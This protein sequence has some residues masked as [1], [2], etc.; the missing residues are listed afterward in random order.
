MANTACLSTKQFSRIFTEYVGASPKEFQRIV[1]VQRVL[2]L[3]QENPQYNFA[4]LAYS[5]GFSDQSHMIREFKLFT[6]YTPLEY[7]LICSPVSD[8]FSD[9]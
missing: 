1:R 7:L 3:L 5:C 4:Q 6:G 9:L 8:Y 2:Y